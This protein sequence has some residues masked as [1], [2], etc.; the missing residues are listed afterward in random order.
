MTMEIDRFLDDKDRYDR[1]I[2]RLC[3]VESGGRL[4]RVKFEIRCTE[5]KFVKGF[6]I[7]NRVH[8]Q[9][10]QDLSKY[11]IVMKKVKAFITDFFFF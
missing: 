1:S 10:L 5:G 9:D 3:K 8:I 11:R 4:G 6:K 2:V 7:K